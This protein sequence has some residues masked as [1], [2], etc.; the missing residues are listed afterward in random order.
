MCLSLENNIDTLTRFSKQ[1]QPMENS[2]T[3]ISYTKTLTLDKIPF[4]K[5][6]EKTVR[7]NNPNSNRYSNVLGNVPPSCRKS[8]GT[9]IWYHDGHR[10]IQPSSWLIKAVDSSRVLRVHHNKNSINQMPVI[11]F[12]PSRM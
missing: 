12:T 7:S 6:L 5:N 1:L 10:C 9:K 11:V 8:S 4:I 3:T 2:L